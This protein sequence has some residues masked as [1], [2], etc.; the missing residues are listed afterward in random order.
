MKDIVVIAGATASGKTALAIALAKVFD[1]EVVSADSMQVYKNMDIGTAKPDMKERDG[2]THHMMDIVSPTQAYSA[3]D[4][5]VEAKSAIEDIL[6]RGKLPIVV[7]GT[8]MYLDVLTGRMDL[9]APKSDGKIREELTLLYENEGIDALYDVFL[10]EAGEYKEKIHKNDIKRIIRA[11]ERSR[12]GFSPTEEKKEK[13]YNSLWFAIDI[14]RDKLYNKINE[15]VDVMFRSGLLEEVK[16]VILP[17]REECTT[18]LQGIGY[19][20]VLDYIDGVLS[21]DETV[22][23]IKKRSRNYAKRQ[24]TWFRRNDEIHWLKAECAFSEAVEIIKREGV[25]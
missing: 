20:E 1:G 14:D 6:S 17:V 24:L 7:G 22:E 21:Y 15:R 12:M 5:C 8:G 2:I 11:V 23:L 3:N 25:R 9:D 10:T 19:K 18:A 13:E 16:N 4:F